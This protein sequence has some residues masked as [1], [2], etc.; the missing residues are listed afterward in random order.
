MSRSF[1]DLVVLF[2][3]VILTIVCNCVYNP[4]FLPVLIKSPKRT[5]YS[6]HRVARFCLWEAVSNFYCSGFCILFLF[7]SCKI[8]RKSTL[9]YPWLKQ[10]LTT[11]DETNYCLFLRENVRLKRFCTLNNRATYILSCKWR[12]EAKSLKKTSKDF[13]MP[14]Q[15]SQPQQ[16]RHKHFERAS[17]SILFS[18]HKYLNARVFRNVMDDNT[19]VS[20]H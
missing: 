8:P 13:F 16:G 19:L 9:K 6:Y 15:Q 5:T 17:R 11:V 3:G 1:S 4:T 20:I 2:C 7:F 10:R 12:T 18:K 14:T